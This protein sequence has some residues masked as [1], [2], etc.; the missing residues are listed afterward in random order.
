METMENN[1][2][3]AI[4]ELNTR[5]FGSVVEKL[6][7]N[8]LGKLGYTVKKSNSISYDKNINGLDDEIKASRVLVKSKLDIENGS[9]VENIINHNK[10]RKL[11]KINCLTQDWDCNIQQ[12]KTD[13]FENLWYVLFFEDSVEIFKIDKSQILSDPNIS[14]SNKQHRGNVGEGQFHITNKNIQYH[15]DNYFFKTVSYGEIIKL[16]K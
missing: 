14:Y 12:I 8:F 4:F 11:K 3:L 6:L 13:C 15:F 9:I 7:E 10:E 2:M 1:L 5:K 16:L